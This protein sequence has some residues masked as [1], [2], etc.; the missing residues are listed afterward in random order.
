MNNQASKAP[1]DLR[2]AIQIKKD[3]T[4]NWIEQFVILSKRTFRERSRD[5]LDKLRLAQAVGVAILL[6]LLWWKS[7]IGTEAQL[8]DQVMLSLIIS[9][10]FILFLMVRLI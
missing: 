8:R 9:V 4:M 7:K 3:W 1:G 5:Y 10:L 6:G 2:L